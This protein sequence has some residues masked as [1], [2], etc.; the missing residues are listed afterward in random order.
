ML[1]RC[2]MDAIR[3]FLVYLQRCFSDVWMMC[4]NKILIILG[5]YLNTVLRSS[6]YLVVA[7]IKN[8]CATLQTST[9]ER[10]WYMIEILVF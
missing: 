7:R 6:K 8:Q 4:L 5:Y 9:F 3:M 2:S 1:Y 10:K